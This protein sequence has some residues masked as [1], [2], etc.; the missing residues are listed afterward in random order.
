MR[1]IIVLFLLSLA[2]SLL[3][4]NL[5]DYVK[6]KKA[7]NAW[8]EEG[9]AVAWVEGTVRQRFMAKGDNLWLEFDVF[10]P[11]SATVRQ[12]ELQTIK[13]KWANNRTRCE[14]PECQC[15]IL[16]PLVTAPQRDEIGLLLTNDGKLRVTFNAQ[17][18][19]VKFL[20]PTGAVEG[21]YVYGMPIPLFP[22]A[23]QGGI[24]EVN[25]QVMET[26]G[27]NLAQDGITFTRQV[28]F[29]DGSVN[30]NRDT[31]LSSAVTITKWV[32]QRKRTPLK[33]G[34]TIYFG[35]SFTIVTDPQGSVSIGLPSG[36]EIRLDENTTADFE[37][38]YSE[39]LVPIRPSVQKGSLYFKG[40]SAN[41]S[42]PN[43]SPIAS[44][45]PQGTAYCVSVFADTLRVP[46]D[47]TL[48]AQGYRYHSE[49]KAYVRN[50]TKLQVLEGLV[51]FSAK[52]APQN[53]QVDVNEISKQMEIASQYLPDS[54]KKKI[55]S[56]LN[57]GSKDSGIPVE[58]GF[59]S[60]IYNGQ[61]PSEPTPLSSPSKLWFLKEE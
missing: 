19:R 16:E 7:R 15:N 46:Y 24:D 61:A 4:Q 53:T 36:N 2:N 34:G 44:I 56:Q 21:E 42:H 30:T 1:T 50:A 6:I 60:V 48:Y 55:A 11:F 52:N 59:E 49:T 31:E 45:Y 33:D 8:I 41:V 47:S 3:A 25:S 54:I 26:I 13:V 10:A 40:N 5:Q 57:F 18:T 58:A 39:L 51:K 22:T 37:V 12:G 29:P 9:K 43:I 28:Q 27:N 23:K 14:I 32:S 35:D 38:D 20:C 17:S